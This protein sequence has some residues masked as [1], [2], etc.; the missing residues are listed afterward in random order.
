MAHEGPRQGNALLVAAAQTPRL[1]LQQVADAQH[2]H[3]LVDPLLDLVFRHALRF[4]RERDVLA[5]VHL[6]VKREE[7]EDEGDVALGGGQ[8]GDVLAVDVDP[9]FGH[10]LQP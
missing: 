6:R 10:G 7:L 1:L 3:N 9:P 5:H 8:P 2:A 4:E